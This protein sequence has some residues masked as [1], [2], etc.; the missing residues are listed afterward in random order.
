MAS[1]PQQS[2]PMSSPRSLAWLSA[3]PALRAAHLKS[4]PTRRLRQLQ[5][6]LRG[7]GDGERVL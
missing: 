4:F 3:A 1:T 7:R 6:I 5:G 2:R